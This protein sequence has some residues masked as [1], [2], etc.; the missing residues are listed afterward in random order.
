MADT[1]TKAEAFLSGAMNMLNN[2]SLTPS[3]QPPSVDSKP[4]AA[5]ATMENNPEDIPKEELLHLMMKMNSRMAAMEMKGQGLVKR[6]STLLTERKHLLDAIKQRVAIPLNLQDDQ[7]LDLGVVI[8]SINKSESQRQDIIASLEK[9]FSDLEELKE[10]TQTALETKYRREITDLQRALGHSTGPVVAVL[11]ESNGDECSDSD[12]GDSAPLLRAAKESND[13]KDYL[14]AE[15]ERLAKEKADMHVSVVEQMSKSRKL[16]TELEQ[17][18][19]TE[20][21]LREQCS[22][23]EE[24]LRL[25]NDSLLLFQKEMESVKNQS[26]EKVLYLQMQLNNGKTK[27]DGKDRELS[28]LRSELENLRRMDADKDITTGQNNEVIQTLKNKAVEIERELDTF[29]NKARES[30]R[31]LNATLLLKAEQESLLGSLRRDLRNVVDAKDE[32]LRRTKEL[33]EYKIKTDGTLIKMASL[34]EQIALLQSGVEDK[35][36]LITRLRAEAHTAEKNHAMR[37]ATLATTETQLEVQKSELIVKEETVKEAVERVSVLQTRLAS[38]EGRLEERVTAGASRIGQLES[39][40]I[41]AEKRNTSLVSGLQDKHEQALETL[42]RDYS[43]KSSLARTLLS[44]KEEEVRVLGSKT[45]ELL[46]EIKS[47]APNEK[48]IFELAEV[49]AKREAVHGVHGNTR[50][51][52]FQQLQTAL[53]ARDLDLAC[54]QQSQSALATEVSELRRHTKREGVN[55]DYLKNVVLQYMS[56][57]VQAPERVSLVPVIAM[58]LQFNGKEVAQVIMKCRDV[59]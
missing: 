16:Q 14:S 51:M 25:K 46:T 58:L 30:E 42:K 38:M 23:L 43:K 2:K 36:S 1:K 13:I 44:E 41:E 26:E 28:T 52:A 59:S 6:K 22:A 5:V 53:A 19:G 4:L 12:S 10:Q 54:V 7:D 57:P 40:A 27:D 29:R 37:T 49:Q 34:S 33:E 35:T 47:G 56:F 39:D 24:T 20:G 15:N 48:R 55:L 21:T 11:N 9:K 3:R 8:E 18:R 32:A 31:N 17:V 50:E 45:Q